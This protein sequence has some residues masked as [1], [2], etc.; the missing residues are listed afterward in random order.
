[1]TFLCF[2]KGLIAE[3][4]AED[5]GLFILGRGLSEFILQYFMDLFKSPQCLVICLSKND[6]VRNYK[7]GG[8]FNVNPSSFVCDV[9]SSKLSVSLITG[10]FILD[11]E[12]MENQVK[13]ALELYREQNNVGFIRA[14]SESPESFLGINRLGRALRN[15]Q[16]RKA[17]MWPRFHVSVMESFKPEVETI[18]IHI[19]QTEEMQMIQC[20]I[21]TLMQQIL[22]DLKSRE[23]DFTVD[24]IL[25][26]NVLPQKQQ[27]LFDD[28][29][30]LKRLSRI[31]YRYDASSFADYLQGLFNEQTMFC[32]S[33]WTLTDTA[34]TLNL[35]AQQREQIPPKWTTIL[36]ILNEVDDELL[37]LMHCPD[38]LI[39]LHLFLSSK[40]RRKFKL[41]LMNNFNFDQKYICLFDP[42]AA[43]IRRLEVF[44]ARNPKNQLRAYFMIY[45]DSLEEKVFLNRVRMEKE[46]FEQL[47]LESANLVVP[48]T[49]KRTPNLKD[50]I[51]D[52]RE[53]RSQLPLELYRAGFN[54][55]PCSLLIGDYVL[56]PDVVI[57]RKSLP[58]LYQSF[59]S[60]RLYD[61]V[62]EMVRYYQTCIL[63][64]ESPFVPMDLIPK[65]CLLTTLF[66]KLK[67]IWSQNY[68]F[69]VDLVFDLKLGNKEPTLEATTKGKNS[70]LD[71]TGFNPIALEMIRYLG[72]KK[73]EAKKHKNLLELLSHF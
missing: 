12:L 15:L 40:K 67:L 69:S 22:N 54:V 1:M 61:Q 47:I 6:S 52:F 31:L 7:E 14:F 13:F 36:D 5:S 33:S 30:K 25:C 26:N 23:F 59:F 70:I 60:G 8:L 9:L 35:A 34:S 64:I 62:T 16:L 39:K 27:S 43:F 41:Q 24:Y 20:C 51:V 44:Q 66:P 68:S 18:E 73:Q 57:E 46:A 11:A 48:F 4:I 45:K 19:N 10:I 50:V 29:M 72:I 17:F 37:I 71:F 58:D 56:T 65:I 49:E 42:D 53:F 32:T 21:L 55:I 3:V 28:L 2:E 63:L 38:T